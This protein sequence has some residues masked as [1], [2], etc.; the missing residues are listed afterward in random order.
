M[1]KKLSTGV[2]LFVIGFLTTI[3]HPLITGEE[4][5]VKYGLYLM[6]LGAF[7]IIVFLIIERIQDNK[8]F[9]KEFSKKDLRP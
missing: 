6:G 4:S 2:I 3:L 7:I 5:G 1:N 9:K 8:E